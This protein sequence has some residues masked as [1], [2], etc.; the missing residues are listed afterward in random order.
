MISA[1][2]PEKVLSSFWLT[3]LAAALS[4]AWLLPN[5][6]PPWSSFHMDAWSAVVL[7]V[8]ALVVIART[9]PATAWHGVSIL[10]AF[11]VFVPWVQ[12]GLGLVP[13]VG[14]AWLS[15]AYLLGFLTAL[16][17]GARWESANPGQLAD[18]L[19]TAIV[20]AALLSVGLQF[21]QWL[22]LDGLDLWSMGRGFGRPFANFGQPNQLGTLLLWGLLGLAWGVARRKIGAWTAVF[23]AV[24]LLFGLALTASR[25]AWIGI[26]LLTGA[27]WMWRSLWSRR[28]VPHVVSGLAVVFAA[29]AMSIGWLSQALLIAAAESAEITRMGTEMRPVVWAM[30][31]DAVRQ[32][33]LWGYGWVPLSVAQM[34]VVANH[35]TMLTVYSHSHNLFLDLVLWC[36]LPLGLA[37]S[38]YL[39]WWFCTRAKKVVQAEDALLILLLVVVANHA[40]LELPLHYAY[41]LLPVGLVMG[42]L[43]TRLG[44]RPLWV[45]GRWVLSVAW[46]S[47]AALLTLFIRDYSRIEASYQALRFEWAEVEN[48][49]PASPPDV[50][51]LNQWGEFFWYVRLE[52][53]PNMSA[54]DLDRMRN[55]TKLYPSAGFSQKLATGL[56]LNGQPAEALLWLKKAC[57][58]SSASQCSALKKGWAMQSLQNPPIAAVKWTD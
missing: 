38:G 25:T 39:F 55:L 24:Y 14:T 36:G 51:L 18:A 11:L 28:S 6:Y 47:A 42:A 48:S 45:S 23:G 35:P 16:L 56:A 27:S 34:E 33:P 2:P 58:V 26:A 31:A 32:H 17:V 20:I 29:F 57:K 54:S 30:F 9:P 37:I 52:P 8:I 19:F 13:L 1:V 46:L 4:L 12:H 44:T 40:M 7:S 5:H 49:V 10:A 50:V 53:S 3:A 15:S 22:V 41:F 43:D 21:H